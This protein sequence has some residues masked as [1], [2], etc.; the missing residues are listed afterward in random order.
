MISVYDLIDL[1]KRVLVG[2]F[3]VRTK[4]PSGVGNFVPGDNFCA[5]PRGAKGWRGDDGWKWVLLR[6]N[7][8]PYSKNRKYKYKVF[9]VISDFCM[10]HFTCV[11]TEFVALRVGQEDVKF[12]AFDKNNEEVPLKKV[13]NPDT[14]KNILKG[15]PGRGIHLDAVTWI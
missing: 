15:L 3:W 1:S 2:N 5:I 11:K 6:A 4:K 8:K 13:C 7:I 9:F 10:A 12:I 14:R